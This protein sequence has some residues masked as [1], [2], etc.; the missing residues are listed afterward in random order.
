MFV[1]SG[2]PI[3][4]VDIYTVASFFRVISTVQKE[5]ICVLL[6]ILKTTNLKNMTLPVLITV[7]NRMQVRKSYWLD[8]LER[9]PAVGRRRDLVSSFQSR[10]KIGFRERF[11]LSLTLL[12][13]IHGLDFVAKETSKKGSSSA[14]VSIHSLTHFVVLSV[15]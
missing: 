12:V 1:S 6:V 8:E 7:C 13:C 10:V 5:L 15:V 4:I 3:F 11:K 14:A 9:C 2:I